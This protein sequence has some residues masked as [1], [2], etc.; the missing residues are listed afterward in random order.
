[1]SPAARIATALAC[2]AALGV[3]C[4]PV[5][6]T[7]PYALWRVC[8][9]PLGA[10]HFHYL[11][12][13]WERVDDA[14]A[15]APVLLLDGSGDAA[16]DAGAPGARVRLEAYHRAGVAVAD[17]AAARGA[18]WSA[19]GYAVGPP[20]AFSNRAGDEGVVQRAEADGLAVAEVMLPGGGGVAVLSLWGEPSLA[21]EDFLLLLRGFEP[22]ASRSHE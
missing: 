9:H 3:A 10:F 14:P 8:E 11:D 20:E 7:D 19:A 6:G 2:A 17:E 13:P 22:R 12:P 16:G 21:G 15:E 18:L 1:M 5:D 4:D